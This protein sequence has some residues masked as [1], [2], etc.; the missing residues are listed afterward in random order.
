MRRT[1]IEAGAFG[2]WLS[3]DG[4]TNLASRHYSS[5]VASPGGASGL[6]TMKRSKS[7]RMRKAVNA[8]LGVRS[9]GRRIYL[10]TH[11]MSPSA[12]MYE[13]RHRWRMAV[14]R[15]RKEPGLIGYQWN[16]EFHPGEGAN[17]GTIHHH[18]VMLF[19]TYWDYGKSVKAWSLRYS[20]TINGLDIRPMKNTRYPIKDT[21]YNVKGC[22]F[23][24]LPF[25][26]WGASTIKRT[27][28]VLGPVPVLE[29]PDNNRGG[30]M[31]YTEK[32]FAATI[33][34]RLN[35][36]RDL[37]KIKYHKRKEKAK[38]ELNALKA[39]RRETPKRKAYKEKRLEL[40]WM[41]REKRRKINSMKRERLTPSVDYVD[42]GCEYFE[43]ARWIKV[44]EPDTGTLCI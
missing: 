30:V 39:E 35:E 15:L 10:V 6:F 26:W 21:V 9:M 17:G 22:D 13:R 41:A 29:V 18:A 8:V 31:V 2:M 43:P 3:C 38:R 12:D 28:K 33:V 5:V 42:T 19:S 11:T 1:I 14:D 20:D 37:S 27:A 4:T 32:D 16:T 25:R 24:S 36:N 23:V 7:R 34:A 40:W 44:L